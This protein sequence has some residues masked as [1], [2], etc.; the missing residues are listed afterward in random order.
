VQNQYL[1]AISVNLGKNLKMSEIIK[2][3]EIFVIKAF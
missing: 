1:Q 3:I 2:G